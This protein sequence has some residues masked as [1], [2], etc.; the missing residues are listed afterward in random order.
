MNHFYNR[1]SKFLELRD[2]ALIE[3]LYSTGAR[4]S[5][6]ASIKIQDFENNLQTVKTRGKRK[7]DRILFLGKASQETMKNYLEY[8]KNMNINNNYIFVNSRGEKI[9]IKG[10]QY[11]IKQR[12]K[13]NNMQGITPHRFRHTFATDLLN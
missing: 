2:K 6:V 8:K 1:N 3:F 13:E 7:K 11:I 5:E 10:I 12:G 4:V 9:S